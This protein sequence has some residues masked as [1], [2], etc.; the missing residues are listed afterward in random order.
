MDALLV[1]DYSLLAA[2]WSQTMAI[3]ENCHHG[4][5]YSEGNMILGRCPGKTKVTEYFA[6]STAAFFYLSKTLDE[7]YRSAF[8]VGVGVVEA[9]V[10]AHN[11]RFG[12]RFSF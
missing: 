1:A 11:F 2:D 12:V 4:G 6:A 9:S 5:T 7:P 10:V 8:L 3:S